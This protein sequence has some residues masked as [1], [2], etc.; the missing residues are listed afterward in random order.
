MRTRVSSGT[1]GRALQKCEHT[2]FFSSLSL[3]H[4]GEYVD[5]PPGVAPLSVHHGVRGGLGLALA[6]DLTTVD[7]VR[8]LPRAGEL[9]VSLEEGRGGE[10]RRRGERE[11]ERVRTA[12]LCFQSELS[13]A[14]QIVTIPE[15]YCVNYLQ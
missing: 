11:R 10:G 3:S 9:V 13:A 1:Y 8:V 12:E 5:R 14:D 4:R 2:V 15:F 7:G 6:A